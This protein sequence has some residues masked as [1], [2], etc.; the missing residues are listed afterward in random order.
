MAACPVPAAAVAS[1]GAPHAA[2]G[3]LLL[4]AAGWLLCRRRARRRHPLHRRRRLAR[5]CSPPVR[6]PAAPRH[7]DLCC[8]AMLSLAGGPASRPA[9]QAVGWAA[10]PGCYLA[11]PAGWHSHASQTCRR[12][13]AAEVRAHDTHRR[14][15][16]PSKPC[17]TGP[18]PHQLLSRSSTARC[19]SS[20]PPPK[21]A[22]SFRSNFMPP[23]PLRSLSRSGGSQ[24]APTIYLRVMAVQTKHDWSVREWRPRSKSQCS[25]TTQAE[26]Q[27]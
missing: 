23:R 2:P 22:V 11:C 8:P 5:C 6:V 19:P 3:R 1:L 9:A 15:R 16:P 17:M 12:A 10:Y 25:R 14:A 13:G 7:T 18:P 24:E 27:R 20:F 4:Q 26:T 21:T